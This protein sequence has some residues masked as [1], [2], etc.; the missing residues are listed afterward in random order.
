MAKAAT[1]TDGENLQGNIKL[2]QGKQCW[3]NELMMGGT[4]TPT[5]TAMQKALPMGHGLRINAAHFAG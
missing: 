4:M 1:K 3:M 5:T 2:L